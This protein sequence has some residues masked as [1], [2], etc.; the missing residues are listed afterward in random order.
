MTTIAILPENPGQQDTRY[1][2]VAG[3]KQSVGRTAGE[4]L[5]AI[6]GQ[7]EPSEAGTLLVV[8]QLLPDRFFTETQQKRLG[9]LMARWRL[10]R[11]TNQSLPAADQEELE[12][13]KD[14]ELQAAIKRASALADGR[15]S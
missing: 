3:T 2:A 7:L 15:G 10:A 9:E 1:R 5:D 6:T 14:T 8:Q 4:A 12:A 13:L 11:E